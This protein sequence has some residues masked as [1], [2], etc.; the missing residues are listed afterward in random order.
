MMEY[1]WS[2]FLERAFRSD[3]ASFPSSP[4][5]ERTKGVKVRCCFKHLL[6]FLVFHSERELCGVERLR[7]EICLG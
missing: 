7:E 2:H 3:L 6:N 4:S 5:T 1:G